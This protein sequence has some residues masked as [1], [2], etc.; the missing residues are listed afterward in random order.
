[1]S[2][3][4]LVW[5]GVGRVGRGRDSYVLHVEC[6]WKILNVPV[7][8]KFAGL[9]GNSPTVPSRMSSLERRHDGPGTVAEPTGYWRPGKPAPYG[10]LDI[11][12]CLGVVNCDYWETFYNQHRRHILL[13]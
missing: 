3:R 9:Q 11:P 8:R 2:P 12:Q 13:M 6:V 4:E 10:N 7:P 5:G 1:M